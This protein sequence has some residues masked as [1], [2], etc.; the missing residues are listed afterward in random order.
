MHLDIGV[1]A[2]NATDSL[3]LRRNAP[4]PSNLKFLTC[5]PKAH[6]K[7]ALNLQTMPGC[8]RVQFVDTVLWEYAWVAVTA[9]TLCAFSPDCLSRL[10][11]CILQDW[12][13]RQMHGKQG[14]TY[15]AQFAHLQSRG[16]A[17]SAMHGSPATAGA[18][19]SQAGRVCGR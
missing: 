9:S 11:M 15:P 4:W 5:A 2:Y 1:Q 12:A 16:A 17:T 18:A 10:C 14:I 13:H 19:A 8:M 3:K 7:L 6:Q